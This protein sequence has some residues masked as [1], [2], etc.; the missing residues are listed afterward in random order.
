MMSINE[1]LRGNPEKIRQKLLDATVEI[2]GVEWCDDAPET[3]RSG[4]V[5][6]A[7]AAV[8]AAIP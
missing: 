5:L 1:D 8:E 7:E 4:A 3:P 6:D 2:E